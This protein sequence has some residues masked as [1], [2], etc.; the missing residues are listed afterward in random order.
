MPKK[1]VLADDE[2]FIAVAYTD[3]LTHAGLE[4]AVAHNGREAVE[5][6]RQLQPDL[7]LL[8]LIMP[9]MD[10]FEALKAL[11]ADPATARLPVAI[12]SNLSQ[13]ADEQEVRRL[14]AIDYMVKAELSLQDT[15]ARVRALLGE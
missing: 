12:L 3:A 14:G 6:A 13:D 15:V 1:I 11:K 2:K 4:V 10:G 8:D 7:I 5:L 9:E